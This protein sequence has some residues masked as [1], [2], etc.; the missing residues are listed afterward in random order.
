[1]LLSDRITELKG[2]GKKKA[3]LYRKL[4]IRSIED[5]LYH[6]PRNYTDRTIIKSILECQNQE[7]ATIKVTIESVRAQVGNYNRKSPMKL[8]VR[9]DSSSAEIVFF[10]AKYL[11]N[12]FSVGDVFYF[13]GTIK[14]ENGRTSIVHPDYCKEAQ[15]GKN[16][17]LGIIPVYGLTE[18]LIQK[19]VTLSVKRALGQV[20]LNLKETLPK[21]I[22]KKHALMSRDESI[23]N[24]HFPSSYDH[25][26]SAIERLVFEELFLLQL[27]LVLVKKDV[28]LADKKHSYLHREKVHDVVSGLPF[29]LTGDQNKVLKEVLDNMESNR[30]MNR[31]IQGDVGSGKTVLALLA[32]YYAHENKLQSALMAPTEILA[33]QHYHYFYE[34]LNKLGV[35]VQLLTSKT[36][37]KKQVLE[38]L[39]NGEIDVL[40][41]THS[42]IQEK[43]AFHNLG[44][45]ITDEQHRFGVR[46]RGMLSSKGDNPD[47]M[48]MSATPIP[49]TLSL[50]LYGD[51]DVSVIKEMPKGRKPIKTHYVK[52]SKRQGMY[53][54]LQKEIDSGRQ[55]YIVC[56]LI[57]ESE[58]IKLKS[59]TELYEESTRK[60]FKKN[61]VGLVHGRMKSDEKD[62]V[63]RE[64]VAGNIEIL[65]AT[66]VIEVG[67]NVPN[68]TIM[69]I[70]DSD[71]FGLAQLHQ[72]RG[73][74]GRGHQQSFCFLMSAKPGKVAKERI[75]MLVNS[76][77]GFEIANKDLEIRGPGEVLGIRQHGLPELRIANLIEHM[78]VLNK[79]QEDVFRL[80]DTEI[81]NKDDEDRFIEAFHENLVI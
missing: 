13:Y 43:V 15:D 26:E 56:P 36:K 42:I 25:L 78:D 38:S 53:E 49:R 60:V 47:V 34:E 44:L 7:I 37:K 31:L 23:G 80:L 11:K 79:V 46:Q 17:F 81:E 18:G 30:V 3:D 76:N 32:M 10:N 27:G 51:V 69:V 61:A 65:V 28:K 9:D 54:F 19:E 58:K 40:I 63:M 67:I 20:N 29:D 24:I 16:P 68:S 52:D 71:R 57:E 59:A 66:T 55:A 14:K 48:I 35:K 12:I 72:L 5:L 8:T 74:V 41:G 6:Y 73:R 64:F 45:V 75:A 4:N 22:I 1:M 62:E 33:E 70:E 77:D 21:S 2:I 50:I 39:E